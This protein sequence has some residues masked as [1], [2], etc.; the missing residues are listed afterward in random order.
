MTDRNSGKSLLSRGGFVRDED[1][2]S[3]PRFAQIYSNKKLFGFPHTGDART[4]HGG[5][6]DNPVNLCESVDGSIGVSLSEKLTTSLNRFGSIC[7]FT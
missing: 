1:P 6:G 2:N 7:D 4:H 5:L 3:H